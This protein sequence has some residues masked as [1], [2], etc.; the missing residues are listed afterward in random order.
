MELFMTNGLKLYFIIVPIISI[1]LIVINYIMA[2]NNTYID[3]TGPFEC[4]FTS[5]R[6]SRITYTVSFILIAIL[7][8]PFD[9]EITTILPYT[10][11]LYNSNAYGLI[12]LVYF[13]I[14]LLIGFI[15]EINTGALYIKKLFIR[16]NKSLYTT[17]YSNNK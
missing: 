13:L 17:L 6:Q 1:F 8:L 3:K 7:F 15:M 9:I 12:I 11:S 10:I 14:A 4:G 2:P 5:F 16:H